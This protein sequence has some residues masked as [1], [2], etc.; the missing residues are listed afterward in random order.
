M[1]K[2]KVN[3]QQNFQQMFHHYFFLSW[4]LLSLWQ[5]ADEEKMDS[6][7]LEVP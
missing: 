1:M 4:L 5:V 2:F 7:S 3:K 6:L